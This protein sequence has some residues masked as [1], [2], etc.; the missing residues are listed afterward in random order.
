MAESPTAWWQGY[1]NLRN[2]IAGALDVILD[3]KP[4]PRE[5][6]CIDAIL[7][8]FR[9]LS[10]ADLAVLLR[11]AGYNADAIKLPE[12]FVPGGTTDFNAIHVGRENSRYGFEAL[13]VYPAWPKEPA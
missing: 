6:E 7:D 8:V 4:H 12:Y 10:L 5:Q 2:R 13:A 9:D 3:D 11:D 1:F